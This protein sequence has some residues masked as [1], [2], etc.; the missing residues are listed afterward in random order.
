MVFYYPTIFLS[1]GNPFRLL[2]TQNLLALVVF[3]VVVVIKDSAG[4]L[5][6]KQP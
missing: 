1:D 4:N 2:L 6:K 3:I 5:P